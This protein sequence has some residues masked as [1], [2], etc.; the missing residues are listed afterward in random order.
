MDT[1]TCNPLTDDELL[2]E[3][4]IACCRKP[5]EI[6]ISVEED[7][8]NSSTITIQVAPED[9]GTVI[10]KKGQMIDILRKLFARIG[11]S[12]GRRIF[13]RAPETSEELAA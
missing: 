7:Q 1:E 6:R 8:G 5:E 10:G 4:L 3:I 11:A 2:K 9:L 12:D 13:I